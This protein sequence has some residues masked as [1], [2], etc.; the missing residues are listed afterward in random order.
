MDNLIIIIILFL[1][2]LLGYFFFKV[3]EI[4]KHYFINQVILRRV[5]VRLRLSATTRLVE[6]WFKIWNICSQGQKLSL[7]HWLCLL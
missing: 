6:N 7:L 1:L 3:G 2:Y 4:L 5:A